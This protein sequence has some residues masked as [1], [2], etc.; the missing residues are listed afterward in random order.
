MRHYREEKEG[1]SSEGRG[2][3]GGTGEGER[4]GRERKGRE[5]EGRG[6]EGGRKVWGEEIKDVCVSQWLHI[7]CGDGPVWQLQESH[8][9]PS[10]SDD[11]T[12]RRPHKETGR[13]P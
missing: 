13:Q 10:P 8:P 1:G 7:H 11:V 3:E 6:R 12:G 2:R 9:H 4:E 5:R